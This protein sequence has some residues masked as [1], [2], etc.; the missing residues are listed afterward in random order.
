MTTA[1]ILRSL[2]QIRDHFAR[3]EVPYHFVSTSNFN[4]LGMHDWVRGWRNLSL[5]DS[6]DGSHPH[7]LALP[8]SQVFHSIQEISLHL[9]RNAPFAD[10]RGEPAARA[11]FLFFDEQVEDLCRQI[12]LEIQLPP[13]RLVREVDSK[14]VTTEIGNEAGVASVP[15]V[16]AR[17]GSYD[18]LQRVAASLGREWVLQTPY[19]DS[20]KTTF[21]ISG[22]GDYG[23]AA[24]VIEREQ[25]VKVMRRIDC[26]PT[27]VEACA[28][29]WGTFVGPLMTELVGLPQLTPYAGGWCGN[30]LYESAFT[31]AIRRRVLEKTQAMGD[32]LYR[33]GYRGT[34]ELDFLIDRDAGEV[35]LGEL[36]ARITGIS[37]MTNQS[38]FSSSHIP[39]FLFHLLEY[40]PGIELDLDVQAFNEQ[41]LQS[42]ASGVS[43]QAI[44][45]YTEH[46]LRIVTEAPRSGVYTLTEGGR[47]QLRKPGWDRHQALGADEV[48]VLRILAPGEYA[49]GGADLAIVFLNQVIAGGDGQLNTDGQ[50]WIAALQTAFAYRSLNQEERSLVEQ[51][52]QPASIK[53]DGRP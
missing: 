5:I 12:G 50:R 23:A 48:Y 13:Y 33:R 21:F 11:L 34:F 52:N 6:F 28:T 53:S 44:L 3:N 37:A 26:M 31:P 35:Y 15:N 51:A 20:G 10:R 7:L 46:E 49:Y 47:L 30:E 8:S 36:N 9:L 17:I 14:I 40:D 45:K 19:G 24:P 22:P 4:M 25:Q 43:A 1:K 18:E 16:L 41:V 39:L 2:P 29:R 42:G 38:H 27:A 32:A